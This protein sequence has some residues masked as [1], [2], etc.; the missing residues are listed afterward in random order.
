MNESRPKA[1]T[2]LYLGTS[3]I[4]CGSRVG[5]GRLHSLAASLCNLAHQRIDLLGL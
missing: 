5:P 4:G 2:F 3:A 1:G